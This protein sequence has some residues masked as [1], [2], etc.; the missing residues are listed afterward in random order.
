MLLS[1]TLVSH[2]LSYLKWLLNWLVIVTCY[3]SQYSLFLIVTSHCPLSW[4]RFVM[5]FWSSCTV[6]VPRNCLCR[7]FEW[8]FIYVTCDSCNFVEWNFNL[9][10][11]PSPLFGEDFELSGADGSSSLV[12]DLTKPLG[13]GLYVTCDWNFVERRI[14][15]SCSLPCLV[16]AP[17]LSEPVLAYL[18]S[19]F[20]KP[21][22]MTASLGSILH[23][24]CI[25]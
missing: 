10:P 17:K 21:L 24:F 4:C 11:F 7:N 25:R 18:L 9:W 14:Y 20:R 6:L 16:K 12:G 5:F 3:S 15:G 8:S 22:V 2:D 19:D 23:Q 13:M 1:F